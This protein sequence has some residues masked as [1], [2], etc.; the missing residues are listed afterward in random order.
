M[1]KIL[2][3]AAVI[4]AATGLVLLV[5]PPIVVSLLFGVAIEGAGVTMSRLAGMALLALGVACWPDNQAY[6]A[7]YGMLTF[8]TLAMLYLAYIGMVG[9]SGILLWPA[10]AAHAALS[11]LLVRAWWKERTSDHS[12]GNAIPGRPVPPV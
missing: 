8:G 10:V 7:L 2:I 3:L 4:E 12:F 6:R 11:L 5:Y 1:K 9:A